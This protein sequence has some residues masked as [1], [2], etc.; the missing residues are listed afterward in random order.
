MDRITVEESGRVLEAVKPKRF[1]FQWYPDGPD[2]FVTTVQ[3]NFEDRGNETTIRLREFGFPDTTSGRKRLLENA[4]G[5]GEA[6]TLWKFYIEHGI[7]Y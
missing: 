2:S 1:V 5:W 6:L 7:R 3:I 4:S